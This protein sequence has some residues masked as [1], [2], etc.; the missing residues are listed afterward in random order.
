MP[1]KVT[2][3]LSQLIHKFGYD[4]ILVPVDPAEEK[5][6]EKSDLSEVFVINNEKF[7]LVFWVCD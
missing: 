4:F 1:N 6:D 5:N 2:T 7:R 3:T